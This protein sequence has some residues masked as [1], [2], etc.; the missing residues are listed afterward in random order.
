MSIQTK[1]ICSIL[2]LSI[3]LSSCASTRLP[4]PGADV[5]T[6]LVLPIRAKNSS[7]S[8]RFGF[9]SIY[10]VKSSSND[11][12]VIRVDMKP[13]NTLGFELVDS[14]KP[15]KYYVGSLVGRP[16]GSG[17]RTTSPATRYKHYFTLEKGKITF[18][19]NTL[20]LTQFNNEKKNTSYTY[21]H[22]MVP[23]TDSYKAEI[24]QTLNQQPEFK[25]WE[26]QE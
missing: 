8:S 1:R 26:V 15:G 7:S 12:A 10:E 20:N 25:L 4:A 11:E 5:D 2:L 16:I 18:F 6:L 14:L 3:L 19:S 21:R 24:L 13:Q 22:V 17:Q 9:Y 23:L